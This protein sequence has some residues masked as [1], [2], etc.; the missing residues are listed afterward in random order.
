MYTASLAAGTVYVNAKVR[1]L[2][3][4]LVK[5]ID[6]HNSGSYDWFE[7]RARSPSKPQ[8]SNGGFGQ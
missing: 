5:S 6:K 2:D 8:N 4:S 1:K 3:N 7:A